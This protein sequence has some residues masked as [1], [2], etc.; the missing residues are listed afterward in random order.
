VS[1]RTLRGADGTHEVEVR[2]EGGRLVLRAGDDEPRTWEVE[3]LRDGSWLLRDGDRVSHVHVARVGGSWWVHDREHAHL[4]EEVVER[5]SAAPEGS[6][7]APMTGTVQELLVA[8]GDH[9]AVGQPLVLL[10][11]MKMQVEIKSPIAGV[12]GA[13]PHGVGE[14]VDGGTQVVVVEPHA[15]ETAE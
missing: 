8:V 1:G 7:V 14:Q 11:A 13:L 9:V 4:L 10:S 6:L 12:V 2:L 15:E 5:G 3:A